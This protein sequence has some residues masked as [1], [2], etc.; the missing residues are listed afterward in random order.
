MKNGFIYKSLHQFIYIVIT[1]YNF[2]ND[3]FLKNMLG[4]LRKEKK[5]N[6]L[7]NGEIFR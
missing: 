1:K 6:G 4:Q 3:E 2:P 5:L 7:T